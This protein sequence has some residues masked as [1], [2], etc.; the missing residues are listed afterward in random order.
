[1][2]CCVN[3]ALVLT[4]PELMHHLSVLVCILWCYPTYKGVP[5]LVLCR[6]KFGVLWV[7]VP[8]RRLSWP[9]GRVYNNCKDTLKHTQLFIIFIIKLTSFQDALLISGRM[10]SGVFAGMSLLW[11]KA[12]RLRVD[13]RV[14]C[15]TPSRS[16]RPVWRYGAAASC[17]LLLFFHEVYVVTIF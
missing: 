11:R 5:H 12:G 2:A 8:M 15:M 1:M 17:G 10:A 14:C 13:S 4:L 7:G 16:Q 6:A 3:V 9:R